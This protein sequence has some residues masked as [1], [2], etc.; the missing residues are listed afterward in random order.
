ML[1]N[2]IKLNKNLTINTVKSLNDSLLSQ[3][4]NKSHEILVINLDEVKNCDTSGM[5]FLVNLK[6]KCHEY[7]QKLQ[8]INIPPIVSDLANFYEISSI[9]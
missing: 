2:E 1:G 6:R 8:F 7:S 3:I 9:L 4:Q 5:A